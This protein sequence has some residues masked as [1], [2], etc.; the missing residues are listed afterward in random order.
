MLV[1][2][3]LEKGVAKLLPL[4]IVWTTVELLEKDISGY[5]TNTLETERHND[6]FSKIHKLQKFITRTKTSGNDRMRYI[7]TL[8]ILFYQDSLIENVTY[9][10]RA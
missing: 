7:D 8:G 2:R 9:Q 1:K 10:D 3:F 4:D 6:G 5:I